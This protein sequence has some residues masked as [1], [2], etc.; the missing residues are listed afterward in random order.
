LSQFQKSGCTCASV[1]ESL[2]CDFGVVVVNSDDTLI[3]SVAIFKQLVNGTENNQAIAH[4]LSDTPRAEGTDGVLFV[5]N[6]KRFHDFFL[7]Q[8]VRIFLTVLLVCAN[9]L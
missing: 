6:S 4:L 1:S 8:K 7:S 3:G 2:H 5:V 9:L